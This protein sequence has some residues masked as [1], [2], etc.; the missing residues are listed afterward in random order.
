M[1][2]SIYITRHGEAEINKDP[3]KKTDEDVFTDLGQKQIALLAERLRGTSIEQIYTSKISRARLTAQK[4]SE[5]THTPVVIIESLKERKM[6]YTG[7]EN[8][9]PEERFEDFKKRL[10]DTKNFLENLSQESILLVS[11][12]LLIKG[13]LAYILFGEFLTEELLSKID[14]T[15]VIDHA[16][17]TK[18]S[19]NREKRTWKIQYVNGRH[20]LL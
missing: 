10:I 12:A 19:F 5:V 9:S 14:K 4:V 16:T 20:R 11:H 2:M 3:Y 6:I 17:I 15:L 7:Q 13:L 8:Y 1:R 18:L